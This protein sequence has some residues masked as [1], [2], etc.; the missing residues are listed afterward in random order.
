VDI[1][2]KKR[3]AERFGL[4]AGTPM[5]T[6]E[7]LKQRAERFGLPVK[8]GAASVEEEEKKRK[9][10]ERFTANNAVEDNTEENAKKKLRS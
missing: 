2:R 5:E 8:G 6:D 4:V 9:R 7:K 10:A 3:R 1:E